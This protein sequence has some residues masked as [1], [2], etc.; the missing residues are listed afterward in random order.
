MGRVYQKV[1][2]KSRT[3]RN[4]NGKTRRIAKRK[5]K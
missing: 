3:K 5:K 2:R 1:V 4:S